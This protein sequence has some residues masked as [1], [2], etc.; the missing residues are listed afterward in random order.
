MTDNL[1]CWNNKFCEFNARCSK[2][3][4]EVVVQGYRTVTKKFAVTAEGAMKR[5]KTPDNFFVTVF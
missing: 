1:D 3:L 2:V 4:A 5:T